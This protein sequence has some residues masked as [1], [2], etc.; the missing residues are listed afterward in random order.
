MAYNGFKVF[1]SDMHV[2]EPWDLWLNYIDPKYKDRA[3]VGTNEF[4]SDL[5]LVHDG[6]VIS[7]QKK[8]TDEGDD[9]VY[10]ARKYGRLEAFEDFARRGWGTDTQLEAMDAEGI[11]IAV[12]FPSRGLFAHAKEYDDDQLAAAISRAYNDWLAE[13]CAA[14]P[15]RMF[16]A[17][18]VPAQNVE[19]AVAETRRAKQELGFKAIFLRPN[20]VRGRNWNN[21]VYDALWAAC[22]EHGLAVGF[23]EG[24][25]C[26]LPV[27]MAERFDGVHEDHM[28]TEHVACHSIEQMY[29]CLSMVGGGVCERFPGLRV[30]F[31]EGN[32]SWLLFWLWRMDDHYEARERVLKD[33]MPLP[34]SEYFKRQCYAGVEAEEDVAVHLFERIGDSNVVFSTDFP[35]ADTRYP[36]AVKTL[37]GQPFT[38][39][40]KRKILWD[41]CARLYAFD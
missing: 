30:A 16:G 9:V 26:E 33:K 40:N 6:A 39:D 15:E 34:P 35:H 19:A 10:L 37:M 18:M 17:A 2:L 27:A 11:D 5:H 1:D 25:P 13:F 4:L 21:P 3:P 28:L 29:A 14:D 36:T 41:N 23:H 7:R 38:D 32:C 8:I 12:L 31:L 20:P 24:K 22:E